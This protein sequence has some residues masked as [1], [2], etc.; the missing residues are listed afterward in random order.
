MFSEDELDHS[1]VRK[2]L[3]KSIRKRIDSVM[4]SNRKHPILGERKSVRAKCRWPVD[5]DAPRPFRRCRAPSARSAD[6]DRRRSADGDVRC[7]RRPVDGDTLH[8]LASPLYGNRG[9]AAHRARGR[10]MA[11]CCKLEVLS[12]LLPSRS[13]WHA[14][15]RGESGWYR[16]RRGESG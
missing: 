7:R 1:T 4:R 2:L 16:P 14:E 12:P 13:S 6:G 15:T 10:R 9:A 5:G 11:K 3:A 8:A